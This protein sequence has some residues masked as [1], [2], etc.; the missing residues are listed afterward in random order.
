MATV[1]ARSVVRAL[2]RIVAE[3]ASAGV[4]DR[5]LLGRFAARRDEAAFA[6]LV[7]RHG[8]M[9]LWTCRRVLHDWHDAE[10]VFQAAF[11]TL[12]RK[13]A[14]PG[15]QD[16]VA[17][18]LYLV[19]YRLA[20]KTR[21]EVRRRGVREAVPA[22]RTS[23]DP[24]VEVSGRELCA[25]LDEELSRL[26]ATYRAPVLLCCLEGMARD[27]A[28]QQL[29]WSFG[30]LKGRLERGR[31]LLRRRL[32]QR[33]L[34][35]SAAL[36]GLA[37]APGGASA[38]LSPLLLAATLR[39]VSGGVSARVLALSEGAL[40]GLCWGKLKAAAAAVL[41]VCVISTAPVLVSRTD[42]Q[43]VPP[44]DGLEIH[45]TG[46]D[47]PSAAAP[48][49][50]GK[51]L[52]GDPLPP[53]TISRLG[54]VRFRQ[55]SNINSV[56]FAPDGK[57]IATA[58]LDNTVRLWDAATGQELRRFGEHNGAKYIAQIFCMAL[59]RDGKL[60]AAA[61]N[62]QVI[63]VWEAATGKELHQLMKGNEPIAALAFAPDGKTL[64]SAGWDGTV[65]LWDMADGTEARKLE[66]HKV[67]AMSVAFALD[68]KTLASGGGDNLIR[69]WDPQTG[70][71]LRRLEGL[72]KPV[73]TV[74][75]SPDGKTLAS[76]G[77]DRT[78]RLWDVASG[79]ELR[80]HALPEDW[81]FRVA[82]SPDGKTLAVASARYGPD[83]PRIRGRLL[84]VEASSGKVLRQLTDG[85]H[86]PTEAVAFSPDGKMLAAVGGHDSTLH[87][88]DVASGKEVRPVGGH[89]GSIGTLAFVP[90]GRLLTAG[91][92]ETAMLW[93]VASQKA[94]RSFRGYAARLSLD[95]KKVL[96]VSSREEVT[97]RVWDAATGKELRRFPLPGARPTVA[98]DPA[99]T[100]IAA[101]DK[102]GAIRLWDVASGK[103]LRRVEGH[104][105]RTYTPVFSPDGKRLASSGDD[106]S[107][108]LWDVAAGKELRHFD[109][110]GTYLAFSA[111][112][113][114]LAVGG[115]DEGVR[116]WETDSGR[117]AVRLGNDETNWTRACS[118]CFSPDGRTLATGS[119]NTQ[120]RL[121]EVFTGKVRRRLEGHQDWVNAL[122][123][124]PDGRFLAGGCLDTSVLVWD[125]RASPDGGK[126]LSAEALNA[127]WA[128]LASE[129][130]PR[131]YAAVSKMVASPAQAVPFLKASLAPVARADEAKLARLVADLDSDDFAT[132]EKASRELEKLGGAAAGALR[133]VLDG[134]P[135][136][137][138]RRR[139]ELLLAK[140]EGTADLGE[141]LRVLR[142]VEVLEQAGT[143]EA[144]QL[145]RRLAGGAPGA[146]LTEE[147][148]AAV[149][150]LP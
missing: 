56:A 132:R 64:A 9:V 37:L 39:A 124:S 134:K 29:G 90:K 63:R 91:G 61:G 54:T 79:K 68:G 5:E 34:A 66:A 21:A 57:S 131:A 88:W 32:S 30:T 137:E 93:D 126:P 121:W 49:R 6:A 70:N 99:G 122:A 69:L 102:D 25:A 8:P 65:R 67:R 50:D 16:S 100:M 140:C 40:R 107:T 112:G 19:A 115:E 17:N 11:L 48:R 86:H 108:R 72:V 38:A 23:P 75:F 3:G 143:P 118:L 148:R 125:L 59:S 80:R 128:D 62:D 149:R 97:A 73:T 142:A 129:D 135:S 111:D 12:A 117:E 84:L 43:S 15:W 36:A 98:L 85:D 27:E 82:F 110:A 104:R 119:M 113:K 106:K 130:A 10:D 24:L 92:D 89:L 94:L 87:L 145:L 103:E 144:R 42:F 20:L 26:P 51:D 55:G 120:I 147:A 101:C 41:A 18:W 78:V 83:W 71:E 46:L 28:A 52:Y 74:A 141:L 45:P 76:G 31:E 35:L 7:R 1:Q 133:K 109:G 114:L 138:L 53:G 136:A 81:V 58:G 44:L 77:G 33:G 4:S 13:A 139:A 22:P 116:V 150:R 2:G 96:S 123:F 95:G 60:L 14:A 105:G 146:R 47:E 127:L